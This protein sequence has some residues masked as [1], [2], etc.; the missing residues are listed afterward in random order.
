MPKA[1]AAS[2]FVSQSKQ[3]ARMPIAGPIPGYDLVE[4]RQGDPSRLQLNGNAIFRTECSFGNLG[5]L[6]LRTT[7]F[8]DEQE[9]SVLAAV[10]DLEEAVPQAPAAPPISREPLPIALAGIDPPPAT[11]IAESA[12]APF[13]PSIQIPEFALHT[14]RPRIR[15]G[16]NPHAPKAAAAVAPPRVPTPPAP[17]KAPS[18]TVKPPAA[19]KPEPEKPKI[20]VRP[21][22]QVAKPSPPAKP[23]ERP[24]VAAKAA[25]TPKPAPPAQAEKPK[26]A[27]TQR[28]KPAADPALPSLTLMSA[29][30]G[31][32]A[33]ASPGVKIGV[34]AAALVV[35]VGIGS[36][37][38]SGSK[39][40][41]PK[42]SANATGSFTPAGPVI[43]GGGWNTNFGSEAAINGGKQISIYRPSAAMTDYRFEFRGLIE[44]KAMGW[45][46]RASDPKNYYVA[47]L[48][49]VKGGLNPVVA[50]MKYAMINGKEGTH[51]QVMLP[52]SIRSRPDTVY[53]VRMDVKGS[54]FT[55][56]VQDQRIDVWSDDQVRIGGVGF[57]T[58]KGE[59]AQIKSSTVSYL[60]SGK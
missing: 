18:M 17:P 40:A 8:E 29:D 9:G 39:S 12:D 47:K 6:R 2:G 7:G 52:D 34:I 53:N 58:D 10:A 24:A 1:P 31:F 57:Y 45:I 44:R 22:T 56:Y 5:D 54:T 16:A 4:P 15:Y 26:P 25:A 36:L 48:E 38:M 23:A 49:I 33:N 46:F 28:P 35:I 20:T 27:P 60:S 55:T 50:L 37:V 51:T 41:S 32:W 13:V 19:P 21:A 59:R 3:S 30:S 42:V 14:L 43:G 11:L